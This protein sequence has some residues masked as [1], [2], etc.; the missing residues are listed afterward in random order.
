MYPSNARARMT[1]AELERWMA[2]E[3]AG[4]YHQ[5]VHHG[6]H[7][8]PVQVWDRAMTNRRRVAIAEPARFVIDFL[9]AEMRRIS[10]EGFQLGL[11]RYWDPL[12]TTIFPLGTRVLVRYDSSP[13]ASEYLTVPYADLRRPPITLA[14]LE[15]ARRI[16]AGQGERRPSEDRIFATTEAQRRIEEGAGQRSRRARRN[17][18]RRPHSTS[19]IRRPKPSREVNYSQ[20]VVPY[21]GE[22]W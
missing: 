17:T 7:A 13:D 19:P 21:E 12:L 1:L 4:H 10:K 18:A 14:E 6:I 20:P 9:P 5:S 22:E 15:R 16:L 8:I 3:I 11:I 2:L